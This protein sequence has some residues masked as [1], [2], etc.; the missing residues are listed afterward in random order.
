MNS[1][2]ILVTGA[3][4][5]G[6]TW[7]GKSIALSNRI[8]YFHEPFN[9][10][11]TPH[12]KIKFSVL[13]SKIIYWF[14]YI[15]QHNEEKYLNSLHEVFTFEYDPISGIRNVH[16][17]NDFKFFVRTY[18]R[19]LKYKYYSHPRLIVKDPIALFSAP[20][21]A[22]RFKMSVIILS[23]H[24]AAFVDSLIRHQFNHPFSNFTQQESLM[25]NELSSFAEEI[26]EF[27][28]NQKP[29]IEQAILL[30]RILNSQVIKFR[31]QQPFWCFRRYE[32]IVINPLEEFESLFEYLNLNFTEE[33]KKGIITNL[34][35][36]PYGWKTSLNE[37]QKAIIREGTQDIWPNFYSPSDW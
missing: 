10:N 34:N 18:S 15:N 25:S 16:S 31:E 4:R 26:I 28:T 8:A 22:D 5:S 36:N 9:P 1:K 35:P 37:T 3:H 24:P 21:L 7:L 19:L 2:P 17:L 33:I 6:T 11:K 13:E 20:W 29:I 30:W 12:N 14:S 27:T 32:D 23:R